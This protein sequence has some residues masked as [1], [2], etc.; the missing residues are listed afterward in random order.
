MIS[1][2]QFKKRYTFEHEGQVYTVVDFLH[3]KPG[4]EQLSLEQS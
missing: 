3:V 2:G 4:K 1:G